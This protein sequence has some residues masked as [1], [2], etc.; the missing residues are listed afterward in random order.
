MQ[1]F[2]PSLWALRQLCQHSSSSRP[3]PRDQDER[4]RR[5]VQQSK[6]VVKDKRGVRTEGTSASRA[7]LS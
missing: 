4:H 5:V 6:H 2:Y 1:W 7:S 3:Q